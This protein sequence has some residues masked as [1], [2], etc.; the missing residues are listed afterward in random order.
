M[1][2]QRLGLSPVGPMDAAVARE[3]KALVDRA[4]LGHRESV[5][6]NETMRQRVYCSYISRNI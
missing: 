2:P 6:H 3:G 1:V 4:K 5:G